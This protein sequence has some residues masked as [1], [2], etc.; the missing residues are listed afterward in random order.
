MNSALALKTFP[1]AA[2]IIA[3][4]QHF[5]GPREHTFFMDK[6][7]AVPSSRAALNKKLGRLGDPSEEKKDALR[8][9]RGVRTGVRKGKKEES[10]AV[11]P[12][13]AALAAAQPLEGK[14]T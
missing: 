10:A 4:Y 13:E 5:G 6:L 14:H 3:F 8:A 11:V 1:K 9:C 7:E 2:D 12:R